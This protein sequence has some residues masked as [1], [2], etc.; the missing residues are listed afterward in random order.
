MGATAVFFDG[1]Y[2]DKVMH[3]NFNN[4]RIDLQKCANE[5]LRQMSYF[6]LIIITAYPIKAALR[7][8]RKKHGMHRCIDLLLW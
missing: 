2:L 4:Q 8:L 3:Y 1:G 7:Q 5:I 6:V